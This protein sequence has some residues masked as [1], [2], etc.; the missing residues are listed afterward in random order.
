MWGSLC[1]L[2]FFDPAYYNDSYPAGKEEV[3]LKPKLTERITDVYLI[4]MLLLFPL[5]F[6]FS[7]YSQITL[8]KFVFLLAAT[9]LWL[10]ALAWAALMRRA[11]A[12]FR[13]RAQIAVLAAAGISVLSWLCCG[14]LR[15]SFLGAGRFDG[16]LSALVYAV[17]F[18]GVSAFSRPKALHFRAFAL[19]VSLVLLIALLQLAG[20]NPLRLYPRDLGYY[21]HG[22]RYSGVYL[23][24]IGN[25]NILDAILCL[26]LPLFF[27]LYVCGIDWFPIVPALLSVVVLWKAGG[28]GL[29][30]SLLLTAL[31]IPPLL[32]NDLWRIRR[33]L[34][35]LAQLLLAA[36]LGA[37][38]QPGPDTPLRFV[39]SVLPA[40]LLA[41]AALCAALSF[42]P[43][44]ARFSPRESTLPRF[45]A[46]LS[47]A[48][49][50]VGALA[51]LLIP[52][53]SGTIYELRETLRGNAQDSFGSS[54]IRVWR[55]CLALIPAR[56]LLGRGP[57]MLAAYLDIPFSRYVP[58]T[59]ETLRSYADNA[60]NIYLGVLVNTGALGLA[61]HLA[62]LGL[63]AAE[64]LRRRRDGLY[65]SL[66]LGLL[67][68]SIHA[69]FGLGLCLSEPLYWLALGL[70]C[71]R[72]GQDAKNP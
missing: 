18:L 10:A 53:K 64:G 55:G 12:P 68:A 15:T 7:G 51:V 41:A 58:E 28:D 23:G 31:A 56:P 8:S 32:F 43:L 35:A 16:L 3:R 47:G 44:P 36:A 39:F 59:G 24:T 52:W 5:F 46:L 4:T 42:C 2:Y 17:I 22:I 1:R 21:D 49:I 38:W 60:H 65:L 63:A 30:L 69:F 62:A 50:V 26:S 27:S 6:G 25:T 14:E 9:G 54:R 40:A 20:R 13:H 33:A 70:L 29:K 72:R 11:Q 66:A 34:L 45:F 57:G 61:A 71:A 67:C 48:A 19:S 37:L